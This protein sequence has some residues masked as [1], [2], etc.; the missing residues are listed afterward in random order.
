MQLHA[1]LHSLTLTAKVASS[2]KTAPT[3]GLAE[4]S[5]DGD[6]D[7]SFPVGPDWAETPSADDGHA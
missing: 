3:I 7:A 5:E 2:G 1:R 4:A 6:F